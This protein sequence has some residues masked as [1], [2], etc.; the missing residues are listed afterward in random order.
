MK[1]YVVA[2]LANHFAF[3]EL[4]S[5]KIVETQ[6]PIEALPCVPF[7]HYLF[8]MK[9]RNGESYGELLL[10]Q[11]EGS[12]KPFILSSH[13]AFHFLAPDDATRIDEAAL[14]QFFSIALRGKIYEMKQY[15][16][17]AQQYP[18][19]IFISQTCRSFIFSYVKNRKREAVKCLPLHVKNKETFQEMVQ[20]LRQ[21]DALENIPVFVNRSE[22]N[23]I[24]DEIGQELSLPQLLTYGASALSFNW[25]KKN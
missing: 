10:E 15:E 4:S 6:L 21:H 11:I 14:N 2:I 19:Y 7:Y 8:D 13:R 24:P 25:G 22:K 9:A 16:L 23:D 12:K 18:T 5:Q 3:Y 1:K 20:E 17:L